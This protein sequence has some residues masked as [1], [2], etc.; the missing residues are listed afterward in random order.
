MFPSQ[1]PEHPILPAPARR[2]SLPL[3]LGLL[4]AGTCLPLLLFAAGLIY[5]NYIRDREEASTRVFD[6]VRAMRIALDAEMAGIVASLEVLANSNAPRHGDLEAFRANAESFLERYP[7]SAISIADRDGNQILNTRAAPGTPLPPRANRESIAQVFATGRAAFSNLFVGSISHRR[8]ITVS[9]PVRRSGEIAYEMSFNVPLPLFQRIITQQAPEG[10]TISIFDRTGTN[11]ARVPNPQLTIGQK[12]SP[13]LLPALLENTAEAKLNTTSLEGVP[14]LTAFTRSPLTGWIVAAGTP[15]ATLTQPLWNALAVTAAIGIGL[16]SIGLA[17]AIGMAARIARG[18]TLLSLMVNELNHRVK[19]TL[20]TV[21]SI[22][23]Q[24]FQNSA[25]PDEATRK[26]DERLRALAEAHNVLSEERWADAGVRDIVQNALAP[27]IM[28][29]S[30][31]IHMSGPDMRLAPRA[32]LMTS[33]VLHE[34]ATNATKYGA[35]SGTDGQIFVDWSPLGDNDER[36][37]LVWRERRGPAVSP[38][39]RKGF[40][41]RLIEQGFPAQLQGRAVLE[42]LPGGVVCTLQC[43]CEPKAI[44]S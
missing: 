41:S 8:L 19:N 38:A 29:G 43:P 11:F 16:L 34:L 2:L 7:D 3:R 30:R 32:A 39:E 12:A 27:F 31:R 23:T 20:A 14:L 24:T 36:M 44:E 6:T 25:N 26:F 15:V 13:T 5:F 22:A 9:V 17:F 28:K 21:Q 4:V 42:F 37:Q 35:L 40:G 33:L 10:W 1:T 18:E